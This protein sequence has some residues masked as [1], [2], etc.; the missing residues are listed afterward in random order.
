MA[1]NLEEGLAVRIPKDIAKLVVNQSKA[2]NTKPGKVVGYL[3]AKA[4][5]ESPNHLPIPKGTILP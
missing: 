3:L 2:I 4:F 5:T 1:Q